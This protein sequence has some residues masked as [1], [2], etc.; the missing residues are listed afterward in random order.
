MKYLIAI[1]IIAAGIG[2]LSKEAWMK[3]SE[4]RAEKVQSWMESSLFP[5][6]VES[7][8]KEAIFARPM[9]VEETRDSLMVYCE[10]LGDRSLEARENLR[11]QL[12]ATVKKWSDSQEKKYGYIFIKFT[13]EVISPMP[14]NNN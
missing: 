4:K 7:Q 9:H 13:D 14:N 6:I 11:T 8:P 5:V 2:Y 10:Y 3:A 1:V 12:Q